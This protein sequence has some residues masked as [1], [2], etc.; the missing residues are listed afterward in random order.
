MGP[1]QPRIRTP[2]PP[3]R[4]QTAH[5]GYRRYHHPLCTFRRKNKIRARKR[6][7]WCR[8]EPV[9]ALRTGCAPRTATRAHPLHRHSPSPTR[10]HS[11][12]SH[13]PPG[14]Y[15]AP[16]THPYHFRSFHTNTHTHT[17]FNYFFHPK[18]S[19]KIAACSTDIVS[20]PLY[21]SA[22]NTSQN[23]EKKNKF[24]TTTLKRIYSKS[25][26]H[27]HILAINTS[28]NTGSKNR[29]NRHCTK[30]ERGVTRPT[31]LVPNGS[32]L[33]AAA[34]TQSGG[35]ADDTCGQTPAAR[36]GVH[37]REHTHTFIHTLTDTCKN[38]SLTTRQSLVHDGKG[39]RSGG[40]LA[41][42]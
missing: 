2:L 16:V 34:E 27:T 9:R 26:Q 4:G 37:K 23:N 15:R 8:V 31:R 6:R 13:F 14:R 36:T 17:P 24:K 19:R 29:K 28:H 35:T 42:H 1:K 12:I 21:G 5:A 3:A 33:G 38:V 39:V 11:L 25:T 40:P 18:K 20:E 32:R 30:I 41:K 10:Y 7:W 22:T